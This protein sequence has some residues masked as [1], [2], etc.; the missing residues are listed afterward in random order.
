MAALQLGQHF[1]ERNVELDEEDEGMD[2]EVGDFGDLPLA[3]FVDGGDDDLER[4]F[5]DFLGDAGGASGEELGGV[6]VRRAADAA[7]AKGGFQLVQEHAG[8][9]SQ[10]LVGWVELLPG[11]CHRSRI[12]VDVDVKR[13]RFQ[14][15]SRRWNRSFFH[16]P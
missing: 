5:A 6:A 16:V 4:F 9:S 12:L 13:V 14:L 10:L 7:L 3:G 15:H 8:F 11:A 2:E 1:L